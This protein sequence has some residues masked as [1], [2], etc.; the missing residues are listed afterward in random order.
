MQLFCLILMVL[1]LA[2]AA[3]G[4]ALFEDIHAVPLPKRSVG[5]RGMGGDII[6]LNDGKLL[7]AYTPYGRPAPATE[8]IHARTSTDKGRTWGEEFV[9]VPNPTP[10]SRQGAYWNP[11]FLRLPNDDIL[12]SYIYVAGTTPY[13]GHNYY[14]RSADEG[15]TWSEQFI[16]SPHPGYI[17]MHN[18][19]L[20]LLSTGRILAPFTYKKHRPSTA[21]HS[22][23][24][25]LVFYSDTNGY[26]WQMSKN[27]IDM[28]PIEADEPHV[29]ELKDGR[30]MLIFR[31]ERSL[32]KVTLSHGIVKL[33]G[34]F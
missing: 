3:S 16:V 1:L 21:D 30:V 32:R 17:L 19:K 9:L 10:P 29:V 31:N 22:D 4:E 27:D 25:S 2:T 26:S 13:Y 8:G 33:K 24:V 12:L 6:Q 18:D 20:E 34:N 5:Y 7:L 14:R 28:L 23:Y 15:Q 11:S